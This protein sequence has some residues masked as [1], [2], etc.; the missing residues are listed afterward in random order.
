[1]IKVLLLDGDG[2]IIHEPERFSVRVGRDLGVPEE[3]QQDFFQGVFRECS[4][5]R[6]DLKDALQPY[7]ESWGWD[8]TTD[9][10]LVYWFRGTTRDDEMVAE[11]ARL[12]RRGIRC[13]IS[14]VQ[15]KY[16][17]DY[18]WDTLGLKKVFNGRYFSCDVGLKKPDPAYFET[19]LTQ[20]G[21]TPEEAMFWD[22]K[23]DNVDVATSL[24]IMAR[25]F[26]NTK[27]FK[28]VTETLLV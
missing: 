9:D 18:I 1:M 26:T 10:F 11:V 5:G 12:R 7:L 21:C 6:A 8:Q 19:V 23:Q 28:T 15:E 3:E 4:L 27:E 17:A 2:V 13:Y 16:R 24:G 14:S 20:I 25:L 22:D